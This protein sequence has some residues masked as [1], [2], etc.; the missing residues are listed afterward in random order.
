MGNSALI[1]PFGLRMPPALKEWIAAKAEENERSLNSEIVQ[2]L[3]E[4]KKQEE[5][6]QHQ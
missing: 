6:R 2:R 1:A 3:K 4:S 5:E